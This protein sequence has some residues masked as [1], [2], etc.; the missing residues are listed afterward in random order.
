[1][2]KLAPS[3]LACDLS[4]LG[5]E[6]NIIHNSKAHYIHI[7]VMDGNFVPNITFGMP[8]IE[9]IRHITNKVFD[10]HLMINN[11]EKYILDFS[12]AGADIITIH[13]EA[14]VD[15]NRVLSLIK[16][17]KKKAC[18]S[19]KPNT[20]VEVLFP[21]LHLLDMVLIMSVEPGFGGQKFISNVL[22][23]VEIISNKI[24]NLNLNVEIEID[25]GINLDNARN[26]INSGANVLVAGSS[27][28]KNSSADT[29]NQIDSFYSIF[30]ESEFY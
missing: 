12:N 30:K 10:V 1:M 23:K 27:V 16:K 3:I 24:S 7:D 17:N 29:I 25:G 18:I 4:K 15:I 21:Y 20:S 5:N 14:C 8:V 11:C 2:I 22:K 19:I 9:S 28:F 6:I 26:V 13:F